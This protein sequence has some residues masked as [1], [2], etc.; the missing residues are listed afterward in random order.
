MAESIFTVI[1]RT[2]KS[3]VNERLPLSGGSL[4][5][6]LLLSGNPTQ[7]FEAVTKGYVDTELSN[8]T[9]YARLDGSDFTGDI[10]G[11]N[12]ILSGDLTV[13]G[14]VTTLNTTNST[15]SDSLILLSKGASDSQSASND[16][17][18]VI[19]RGSGEDNA[20]MY[21]DETDELFKLSTTTS[22][23]TATNLGG[24]STSASLAIADL[25]T[26]GNELGTIEQF[27]GNVLSSVGTATIIKS[28]FDAVAINGVVL[29]TGT[30]SPFPSTAIATTY[31]TPSEI[32]YELLEVSNDGTDT[33]VSVKVNEASQSAFNHLISAGSLTIGV[34]EITFN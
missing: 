13:N 6:P 7:G 16:S 2:T 33:V 32:V 14:A 23:A 15:I 26:N 9:Q 18:I 8:L 3:L 20:A 24:T 22:D 1:G 27:L 21:W 4:T 19:E 28:E 25:N 17:G 5:G 12:L 31:G 11:T 30:S 29:I 34:E 10:T